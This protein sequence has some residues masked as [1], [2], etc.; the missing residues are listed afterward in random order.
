MDNTCGTHVKDKEMRCDAGGE[1][2][3]EGR[4]DKDKGRET[5]AVTLAS[6]SGKKRTNSGR[7]V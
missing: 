6:G 4:G 3:E 1:N 5:R 7:A 2:V